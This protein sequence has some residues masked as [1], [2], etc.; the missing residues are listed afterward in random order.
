MITSDHG[1]AEEMYE[2]KDPLKPKTSHTT[3]FVPLIIHR[4]DGKKVEF[5]REKSELGD[6]SPTILTL[7]GLDIP[8]D[9]TGSSVL[10][11]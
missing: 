2:G 9:M 8:S 6:V 11:N 4:Y 10:K 7:M 1:N 3:N 5:N